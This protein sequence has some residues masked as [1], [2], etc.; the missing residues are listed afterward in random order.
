MRAAGPDGEGW[1]GF[2]AEL[3][4]F[5]W[6][7]RFAVVLVVVVPFAFA[8][9]AALLG[10]RRRA[11]LDAHWTGRARAYF[12]LRR[13][14]N[15]FFALL[16][17]FGMGV[18][19]FGYEPVNAFPPTVSVW[20]SLLVLGT[21]LWRLRIDFE[22]AIGALRR[23]ASIL[24]EFIGVSLLFAPAPWLLLWLAVTR[25]GE[26]R[27]GFWLALAASVAYLLFTGFGGFAYLARALGF[28]EP[29]REA[30]LTA[31]SR[32]AAAKSRPLP[33]SY[34][35]RWSRVNAAALPSL[36]W[37]FFTS[38][39]ASRLSRA[40]LEAVAAH[41][42]GH[43]YEPRPVRLLRACA[44]LLWLP[45]MLGVLGMQQGEPQSLLW[46]AL[47]FIVLAYAYGFLQRRLEH[48]ADHDAH[49]V[50]T[51]YATTLEEIHRVN[52]A[53]AVLR[54]GTHPSLY[55]RMLAAGK[56]PGYPRPEPPARW[57]VLL[58]AAFV[59]LLLLAY[60][61]AFAVASWCVPLRAERGDWGF[62]AAAAL[63]GGDSAERAVVER[64]RAQGRIS[65]AIALLE[66][67]GGRDSEAL[68]KIFRFQLENADCDG[69]ARTVA[70]MT[71]GRERAGSQQ[72]WR[73]F[74]QH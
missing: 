24:R 42:L 36:G 1:L 33:P 59:P 13:V 71:A 29:A 69:A 66:A 64:L 26:T 60:V 72:T 11:L 31:V 38:D 17:V 6:L 53:P 30:V 37:V 47:A 8:L 14:L 45:L 32:A 68:S 67:T 52:L 46:G 9:K 34:E 58:C 65:D 3:G 74:C 4:L 12:P 54:G 27:L 41:E 62:Y 57:P 20:V 61:V 28:L 16:A 40:E 25:A 44:S 70:R 51:D 10:W 18:V 5:S 15:F 23:P 55:D 7:V 39:A 43:L 56:T 50:S 49:A 73:A 63:E 19:Q 21:F 22:I 2:A 35:L 48:D